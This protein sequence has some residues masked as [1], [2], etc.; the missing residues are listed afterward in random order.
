MRIGIAATGIAALGLALGLASC[1][2]VAAI[3]PP[4]LFSSSALGAVV[5][6]DPDGFLRQL[7][8]AWNNSRIKESLPID[9]KS[10][11]T[12]KYPI[13]ATAETVVDR[14]RPWVLQLLPASLPEGTPILLFELPYSKDPQALVDGMAANGYREAGRASGY[15]A[16]S[17]E[18]SM[19]RFPGESAADTHIL[20]RWPS[21]S[22]ALW[23]NPSALE[24]LPA[25]IGEAKRGMFGTAEGAD[26]LQPS[27]SALVME[28]TEV[29]MPVPK[30]SEAKSARDLLDSLALGPGRELEAFSAAFVPDSQAFAFRMALELPPTHRFSSLLAT[31]SHAGSALPWTERLPKDALLSCSWT[32]NPALRRELGRALSD[33]IHPSDPS[34]GNPDGWQAPA[35]GGSPPPRPAEEEIAK[36]FNGPAVFSID[37]DPERAFAAA[38]AMDKG[39]LDTMSDLVPSYFM[40]AEVSDRKEAVKVLKREL[41]SARVDSILSYLLETTGASISLDDSGGFGGR[42]SGSIIP[43]AAN[44][45]WSSEKLRAVNAALAEASLRWVFG[46]GVIAVG[47][48][49]FEDLA[50][51]ADAQKRVDNL[52]RSE[53]FAQLARLI[54]EKPQF[55]LVASTKKAAGMAKEIIAENKSV[56]MTNIQPER[57]GLLACWLLA[58]PSGTKRDGPLAEAGIA[59]SVSDLG[60]L[61]HAFSNSIRAKELHE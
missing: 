59:L 6:A 22:L 28:P 23:I 48:A 40:L 7:T 51:F 46:P 30:A 54:P 11:L 33:T 12:S 57:F 9:P 24:K 55:L 44:S 42:D 16:F 3:P 50:R 27:G 18:G 35:P 60:A 61:A 15:I 56:G 21:T 4:V 5:I 14:H 29:V 37:I 25:A 43:R 8:A 45:S 34:S 17:E 1:A 2:R 26:G 38:R 49:S 41:A 47:N 39:N 19:P 13:L 20:E 10:F 53:D 58:E 31:A 32:I 52:A 36:I